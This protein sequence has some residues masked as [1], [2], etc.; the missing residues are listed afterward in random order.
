[1]MEEQIN[2]HNHILC[3]FVA[4]TP[5]IAL[6][7]SVLGFIV[8]VWFP[9]PLGNPAILEWFGA[10]FVVF[11]P[12]IIL[13]SQRHRSALYKKLSAESYQLGTGPYVFSRHPTYVGILGLMLG[14]ACL[15]NS[16]FVFIGLII[17]FLIFHFIIVPHEEKLLLLRI[18]DRY[19]EYRKNVRRWV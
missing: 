3:T 7:M 13:W 19:S 18:G 15:L 16:F 1:M 9:V 2:E 11:S 12:L 10:F 8:H 14:L 4:Y 5:L 6:V 17:T